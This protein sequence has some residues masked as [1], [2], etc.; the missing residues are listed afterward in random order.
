VSPASGP[1][2]DDLSRFDHQETIVMIDIIAISFVVGF[3]LVVAIAV[4]AGRVDVETSSTT[5]LGTL[6]M[7]QRPLD[8]PRGMQ[9]EDLPPFIFHSEASAL[10]S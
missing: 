6:F 3:A 5:S 8:R 1:H 9:E 2:D 10:R 7:V 4:A